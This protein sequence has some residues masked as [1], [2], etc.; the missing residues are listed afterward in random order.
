MLCTLLYNY[1]DITFCDIFRQGS[2]D[3]QSHAYSSISEPGYEHVDSNEPQTT[4]GQP[5]YLEYGTKTAAAKDGLDA[6]PEVSEDTMRVVVNSSYEPVE[7]GEHSGASGRVRLE[8]TAP[9]ADSM[10]DN[11]AY[12]RESYDGRVSMPNGDGKE[13]EGG[14]GG[15]GE[16]EAIVA[17]QSNSSYSYVTTMPLPSPSRED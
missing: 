11:R 15:G 1:D 7:I 17:L 12:N 2:L 13:E 6:I 16:Y 5:R 10:V 9:R 3:G 14:E 8:E 4:E